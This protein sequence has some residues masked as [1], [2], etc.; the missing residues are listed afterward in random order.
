MVEVGSHARPVL[1]EVLG[2]RIDER[3]PV[4]QHDDGNLRP[5]LIARREELDALGRV[6][7]VERMRHA[8]PREQVPQRR[9]AWRP[10]VRHDGELAAAGSVLATPLLQELGDEPMEDLVRRAE[11][12]QRVVVDVAERHCVADRL[13]GLL[14]RPAAPRDEQRPLRM[15]MQLVDAL[16]EL[17]SFQLARATRSEDDGDGFAAL[18]QLLQLGERRFGRRAADHLVVARVALELVRDPLERLRVLVDREDEWQLAH[19]TSAT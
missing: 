11:R 9:A 16:E 13:R 14:V 3:R 6:G 2:P 1:R 15:R 12:L 18:L 10:R 5:L 7:R 19:P 8:V 4:L 17:L